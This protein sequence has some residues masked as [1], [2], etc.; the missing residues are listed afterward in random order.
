MNIMN[1]LTRKHVVGNK[2]RTLITILGVIISVAMLTAVATASAS[3]MDFFQRLEIRNTGRWMVK[4]PNVSNEAMKEI[5]QDKNTKSCFFTKHEGIALLE[6]DEHSHHMDPYLV[7][8]G[9]DDK[10]WGEY[11]IEVVEGRLPQNDR[12]IIINKEVNDVTSEDWKVGDKVSITFGNRYL[13]TDGKKEKINPEA[14][15]IWG[16]ECEELF[17]PS[18]VKKEYT[19]VGMMNPPVIE[20]VGGAGFSALTTFEPSDDTSFLKEENSQIMANVFLNK[21]SNNLYKETEELAQRV[22]VKPEELRYN[23]LLLVYYGS[24]PNNTFNQM[25]DILTLILILII[26]VGSISLIYNSFAISLSERSKQF[27]MLSSVGATKRQK[28]NAVFYEGFV[29]GCISIPIGIFSGI[30]GMAITFRC[31][32]PLLSS[33]VEVDEPLRL[34]VSAWSIVVAV[35]YSIITILI[36]A[37]IPARRAAKI[38]PIES[39][40]QSKDIKITKKAVKTTKLTRRLFGLEGELAQKNLKRNKKRYRSLVFSLFVSIVLF[41]SV[42][43]YV[44]YLSEAYITSGEDKNYDVGIHYLNETHGETAELEKR[45]SELKKQDEISEKIRGLSSV[46]EYQRVYASN[47]TFSTLVGELKQLVGEEYKKILIEFFGYSQERLGQYLQSENVSFQVIALE[48]EEF[49]QYATRV[50]VQKKVLEDT[51]IPKAILVNTFRLQGGYKIK[52]IAPFDVKKNEVLSMEAI[53]EANQKT[54]IKLQIV[55][56]TEQLVMGCQKPSSPWESFPLVV[57]KSTLKKINR[58]LHR[59]EVDYRSKVYLKLNQGANIEKEIETIMKEHGY[60]SSYYMNNHYASLQ[61]TK[62]MIFVFSVFAYGF[63]TLISL[64]CIANLCNT[65]STSFAIRRREFAMLK[66]VGMTPKQ[67]H[68]MVRMESMFYGIKALLFGLPISF[69]VSFFIYRIVSGNVSTGYTC[70][71]HAFLFATIAVFV[72]VGTAMF[73]A[74]RKIRKENIM[75]GLM[76]EN[77]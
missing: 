11:F 12:E 74:S 36:S 17:V 72:V 63:I 50:G 35:I 25:I 29:I 1:K 5:E 53:E 44:Y 40:R 64:I 48:D 2:K 23:D 15:Y 39:I 75:D 51:T 3:F 45:T 28:Q 47:F 66:S 76:A 59:S 58:D 8:T 49:F 31:V 71:I 55:G 7:V 6:E 27:G 16:D 61:Q 9:M 52:E 10:A 38:T 22:G 65:I 21:V 42:S 30:L 77:I 20:H 14:P 60:D 43:S 13:V 33:V 32:S 19:I 41:I 70:P 69:F 68:K 4:F 18:Q 26:M 67:F 34:V 56:M 57:A 37:Y 46:M 24:S 54:Q 73:Y 62:Q